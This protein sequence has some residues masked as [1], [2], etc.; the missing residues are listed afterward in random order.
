MTRALAVAVLGVCLLAQVGALESE[1]ADREAPRVRFEA[2]DVYVD[3]GDTPLAAY[4][5]ELA[6]EVGDGRIVGIE[7]GSHPAFREPPYYDPAAL[8]KHRVIIAAFNTGKD[9]PTGRTRVARLH[10]QVSGEIEPEYVV[11]LQTAASPD[12]KRIHATAIAGQGEPK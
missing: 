7:G 12:G 10:V 5:F 3:S 6:A 4:P 9:L 2:V 1:P 11:Q 8:M